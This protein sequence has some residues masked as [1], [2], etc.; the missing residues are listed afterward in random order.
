[1]FAAVVDG[2]YDKVKDLHK[3]ILFQNNPTKYYEL[4]FT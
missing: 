2:L 1:M 4:E 3:A